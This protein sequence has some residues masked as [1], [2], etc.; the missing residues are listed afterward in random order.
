MTTSATGQLSPST[1]LALDWAWAAARHRAVPHAGGAGTSAPN[2]TTQPTIGPADLLVGTL[3]AHPDEDGEGRVLLHHFGLTARDVL[4]LGY[5]KLSIQ[6]LRREAASI[7]PGDPHPL[8]KEAESVLASAASLARGGVSHLRY[9]IGALLA[10]ELSLRWRTSLA[11]RGADAAT[12]RDSYNRWLEAERNGGTGVRGRRLRRWLEQE[13]PRRPVDMPQY[14]PDRIDSRRDHIGIATEA[15]AFARLIASCDLTPPLAIALFGDW[16]SGKSFLM[17]AIQDRIE[18]LATRVAGRPQRDVRVWKRIKQIDFNAWE[19]V[20]GNLW[21][22]LLENIFV[23]LGSVQLQLVDSWRAPVEEQIAAARQDMEGGQQRVTAARAQVEA[24]DTKVK[25]AE[26]AA[27]TA[28]QQAEAAA[29][30]ERRVEAEEQGRKA[31]K[32]FWGQ[33][34]VALAD[35]S[36]ADLVVAIQQAR[37]ELERG[38]ALAA[39]WKNWRHVA[40]VSLGLLVAPVIAVLLALV[41]QISTKWAAIGGL[42]SLVP[43]VTA[44]LRAA[45]RWS[46]AVATELESAEAAVQER[47]N[48]PVI[49]AQQ[50][51]DEAREAAGTARQDLARAEEELRLSQLHTADL[52]NELASLTPGRILVNFADQRSTEYG[53]RLGLLGHVRR[54]L[55]DLEGSI[56]NR[57]GPRTCRTG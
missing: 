33:V 38:K 34:P 4:P 41:P 29:E 20:Q 12:V 11:T 24:L 30:D 40:L 46:G 32:R 42:L 35:Q 37:A 44:T 56:L 9:L 5:P 26:R 16:G 18:A 57:R 1:K 43:V 45:T 36:G 49:A 13:N 3:L 52:D 19:Y 21:A 39:Y 55:G 17:S 27:E 10:V 31:L 25:Q 22:S 23:Q 6:D 7:D 53:R 47:L 51:V 14:A 15:E 50:A 28:A 54:D 8:D 2:A 48:A